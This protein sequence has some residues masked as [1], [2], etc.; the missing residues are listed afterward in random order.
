MRYQKKEEDRDLTVWPDWGHCGVACRQSTGIGPVDCLQATPPAKWYLQA[1][2]ITLVDITS[3]SVSLLVKLWVNLT[4]LSSVTFSISFCVMFSFYLL[5]LI[6]SPFYCPLLFSIP[7]LVLFPYYFHFL[8]LISVC[9]W[10]WANMVRTYTIIVYIHTI[11]L[12]DSQSPSSRWEWLRI[13][14]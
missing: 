11:L 6:L 12:A 2:D 13:S 1:A 5:F 9:N 3:L 8:S 14:L 7:R 10:W 4:V